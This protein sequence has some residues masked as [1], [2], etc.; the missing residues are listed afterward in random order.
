MVSWTSPFSNLETWEQLRGWWTASGCWPSCAP[1]TTPSSRSPS[2]GSHRCWEGQVW[3]IGHDGT[4]AGVDFISF[5]FIL[6][7]CW[8]R[9]FGDLFLGLPTVQNPDPSGDASSSGSS[10]FLSSEEATEHCSLPGVGNLKNQE[11]IRSRRTG[12]IFCQI[13]RCSHLF[14]TLSNYVFSFGSLSW[15]SWKNPYL[16][17]VGR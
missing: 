4:M 13:V 10:G 17:L 2:R 5:M 14:P 3:G 9:V 7:F 12:P 16:C 8:H 11:T 15:G 1:N 6:L